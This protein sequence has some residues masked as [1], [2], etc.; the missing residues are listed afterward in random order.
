MHDILAKHGVIIDDGDTL[1]NLKI[2][3][4]GNPIL[5]PLK[6]KWLLEK[7]GKHPRPVLIRVIK[8]TLMD[9]LRV[10]KMMR[11]GDLAK[12]LTMIF[13]DKEGISFPNMIETLSG[14]VSP[15]CEILESNL[16]NELKSAQFMISPAIIS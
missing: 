10:I 2:A 1:E 13:V 9:D 3:F 14:K 7:N 12:A 11:N 6:I 16:I 5:K 8:Q 4:S 15:K